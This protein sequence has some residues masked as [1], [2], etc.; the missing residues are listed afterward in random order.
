MTIEVQGLTK[1]FGA[2][3][4]ANGVSLRVEE[5]GLMALL[6]PSGSGKTTVLRMIAG[7]ENPDAGSITIGG[8]DVTDLPAQKRHVGFVFQHYA[9]FKHMRVADNIAFPLKVRHWR[10]DAARE[11]VAELV[12][13]LRLEGLE[14][15]YPDEVSGGQQ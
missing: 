3:T 13:L 1:H 4:A 7:L 10:K 11:R 6:G 2:V 5:G 9:L 14:R 12:S 15:R 8:I